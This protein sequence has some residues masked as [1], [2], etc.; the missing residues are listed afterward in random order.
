MI[1]SILI[2][3]LYLT[4]FNS[5]DEIIGAIK[6]DIPA[7]EAV[8][9]G[10]YHMVKAVEETTAEDYIQ[11]YSTQFEKHYGSGQMY[12]LIDVMGLPSVLGVDAFSIILSDADRFNIK[13]IEMSVATNDHGRPI[14]GNMVKNLSSNYNVVID[15]TFLPDM[16]KARKFIENFIIKNEQQN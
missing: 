10:K 6:L 3:S 16:R 7:L 15:I 13:H 1:L 4:V 2:Y 8:N 11:M 12:F 5:L 14:I 9:F